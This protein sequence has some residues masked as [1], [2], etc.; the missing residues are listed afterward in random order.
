MSFEAVLLLATALLA[1]VA[2][3]AAV[4][5]VRAVRHLDRSTAP[6][7]ERPAQ[8]AAPLPEQPRPRADSASPCG[9]SR[10]ASW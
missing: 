10:D 8:A 3:T 1:V 5:A 6:A 2:V 4:V 9:S 7:S